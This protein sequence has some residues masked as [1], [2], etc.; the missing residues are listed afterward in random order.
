M[1]TETK[2]SA[3]ARAW[4]TIHFYERVA[5][6][7]LYRRAFKQDGVWRYIGRHYDYSF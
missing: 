5:F 6:T 3:C 7:T 2:K 1:K 4:G